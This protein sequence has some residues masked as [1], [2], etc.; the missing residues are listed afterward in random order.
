MKQMATNNQ[1]N[2]TDTFKVTV[3]NAFTSSRTKEAILAEL[4]AIED[5]EKAEKERQE[6]EQKAQIERE[7]S[8]DLQLLSEYK[9]TIDEV[10]EALQYV[11]ARDEVA[12]LIRR[13][14]K[15]EANIK[16][17]ETKYGINQAAQD[18]QVE[19][20]P[21]KGDFIK[22]AWKIA[23]LLLACWGI[24]LY[25]GD[26]IV[27]KYPSAAVYNEVS[28]QK[29][30]F[31]FSVFVGGVVSTVVILVMFFPGLGRYFNPFNHHSLDF[32]DDFKT[33]APWQRNVV[34]LVLFLGL[35]LSYV[36]IVAG[37]LD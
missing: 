8:F 15:A 27:S 2:P 32:F 1:S 5:A 10:N 34:A 37:K 22:T 33:L 6:L 28:F 36:L 13:R 14:K 25:S 7:R 24:V 18:A 17:I 16:D 26:W 23:A 4:K 21:Q 19:P 12:E 11:S 29:V 31:G 20:T 3:G 35:L 30:L 9:A